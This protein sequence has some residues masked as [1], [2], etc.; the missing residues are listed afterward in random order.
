VFSIN[1][2]MRTELTVLIVDDEVVNI[3]FVSEVL[4]EEYNIK[5]AR[6]GQQAINIVKKH[7]IDLILLDVQMPEKD[8]YQTA[9][10]LLADTDTSHIPIIFL[11]SN[12]DSKALVRGFQVGA[13]DY[14]TKPFN[15]DEL[16]ARTKNHI[17][18]YLQEQEIKEQ[19][20]FLDLVLNSQSSMIVL[21]NSLSI[22]YVNQPFLDFFGFK[23]IE[24]FY[25]SNANCILGLF[26]EDERY[27]HAN[28]VKDNL[29]W[30]DTI[31]YLPAIERVV[32]IRSATGIV[33]NFKLSING[34]ENNLY[35]I[36][37]A[38]ITNNLQKQH[39]LEKKVS[40]DKLTGAFT[41]EYFDITIN[42]I[43]LANK[44]KEI[45]T[46][47]A[48]LDIDYFKKVNDTY[49]H[50]IGDLVLQKTVK[51]IQN[52]SRNDDMLVRWGGEEFII[53]L[54]VQDNTQL[55]FALEKFR[56]AIAETEMP[57]VRKITCSFGGTIYKDSEEILATIKRADESLYESKR[58]GRNRVTLS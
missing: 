37:F 20:K 16:K 56:K 17:K 40:H 7:N 48:I 30:I 39:E 15:V 57:K 11:T 55:L 41:R 25:K 45:K 51:K 46:A 49:G 50:D 47:F 33:K 14:I 18:T 36:D 4:N 58:N 26:I 2:S 32:A 52:I 13:K 3:E 43:I 53:V 12:R 1:K 9:E 34:F 24:D 28:K 31:Q 54:S 21:S 22:Q 44:E 42:D 29:T 27:F 19:Q 8:G 35:L 6:S 5:I 23:N 10:E 38:D